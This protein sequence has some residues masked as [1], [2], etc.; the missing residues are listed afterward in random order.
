MESLG[1]NSRRHANSGRWPSGLGAFGLAAALMIA[2][3]SHY[4]VMGADIEL[5]GGV[6]AVS[7]AS[8][9]EGA[10]DKCMAVLR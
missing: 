2:E 9:G 5:S 4:R 6:D 1:L 10:A 8:L 7:A 3:A